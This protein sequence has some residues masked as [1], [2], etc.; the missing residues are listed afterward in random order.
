M[1]LSTFKKDLPL[2]VS[3]EL[4][5]KEDVMSTK[6]RKK[7]NQKM[8]IGQLIIFLVAF[9]ILMT[10]VCFYVYEALE[11]MPERAKNFRIGV[12]D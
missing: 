5:I 7:S 4:V 12:G 2:L 11:D 10:A 3:K 8:S 9:A 1:C 6:R